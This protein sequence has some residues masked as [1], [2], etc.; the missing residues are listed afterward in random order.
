MKP[1][2][3]Y[4]IAGEPSGDLLG[5]RLMRALKKQTKGSV[6]FYGVGG[7]AMESEGLHSLF[8][9]TDLAVMGLVEV[10]PS[11]PRILRRMKEVLADIK[12]RKPDIILSID[13]YSFSARI[14]Q[15]LKKAGY[16][17]PHAHCVAPQVWA[18]KKGRA[19]KLGRFVD[20]LFCLLPN[21]AAYFEPHGLETT[22]IGHPVIEGG[23]D[24]GDAEAF[25]RKYHLSKETLIISMLPGSRKNE[26]KYLLPVFKQAAEDLYARFPNLFIVL[27]TVR[28]VRQRLEKE[29]KD[30]PVPHVFV[31]GEKERYDAF[32]ASKAALAA[33]GTV[34]LELAMAGVPHLIAY[35]VSPLTGMIVR[36]LLN[37]RFANLLN[38]L[39]NKEIIPEFLQENC[40]VDKVVAKMKHF[41]QEPHQDVS[42]P[43]KKLGLGQKL[44]P[45]DKMATVLIQLARKDKKKV[46]PRQKRRPCKKVKN[47]IK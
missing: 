4:L 26:I 13:S 5:A 3:V 14:H 29:L 46:S 39:E 19:K 34:S 30:W 47:T 35:K 32:A 37:V 17:I 2:K 28:T 9:I 31:M 1:I 43:L 22:F 16:H 23:A 11:I 12:A 42:A 15:R 44:S 8:D 41:L 27:P 33:S 45:S 20:H 36:R 10:I 25:R 6:R 24:K 40:T 7:E 38:L 18:W 21:E